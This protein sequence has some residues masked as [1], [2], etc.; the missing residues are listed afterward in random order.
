VDPNIAMG[1]LPCVFLG[2]GVLEGVAG[3]VAACLVAGVRRG[4]ELRL[5]IFL[6]FIWG[7]GG[8]GGEGGGGGGCVCL[9]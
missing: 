6:F 5:R 2:M 3:T 1:A 9:V 4:L 8:G 7:G